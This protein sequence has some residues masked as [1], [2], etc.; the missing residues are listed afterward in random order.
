[1]DVGGEDSLGNHPQV[2]R[3]SHIDVE[4]TERLARI[5][6][7]CLATIFTACADDVQKSHKVAIVQVA[8]AAA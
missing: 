1:M 7:N 4:P 8:N 5:S 2:I 6:I 3:A